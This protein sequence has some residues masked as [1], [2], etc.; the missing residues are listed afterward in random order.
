VAP[1]FAPETVMADPIGPDVADKL[2]MLGGMTTVNGD[3]LLVI[4]PTVT[5]T[6]PLVALAGTLVEM[7]VM[8]QLVAVAATP[9]KLTVL[10]PWVAP[11]LLPVITTPVP[12]T[13]DVGERP[14]IAGVKGTV[15]DPTSGNQPKCWPA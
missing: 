11:K 13:P 2:E 6:F 9:L 3:P 1:K 14:L 10:V 7:L 15:Q 5:L 4:L 8:L 12:A